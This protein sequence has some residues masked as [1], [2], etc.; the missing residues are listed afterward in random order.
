MTMTIASPRAF[1]LP[2]GGHLAH[3]EG[4][5]GWPLRSI[6]WRPAS[7]AA[8]IVLLNGRG[9]F[10]E[11]YAELVAD[12][13]AK[14]FAVAAMDWRG[15]GLSGASTEPPRRTHIDDFSL[16]VEDAQIWFSAVVA[17]LCPAP[18]K[19]L[20]HS[21]GSHLGLRIL[22]DSP[23]F[24]EKAALLVPMLG[25]QTHPFS[26]KFARR[27]A[28][29]I[30]G[31][32]QGE[33][34]SF[35][36]LPYS[37]LFNNVVR[38]NRLTSDRTRFDYEAAAIA[39]NPNLAIGGVSYGWAVAAFNSCDLLATAG[40]AESIAIPT[41]ILAAEREV[42]VSNDA[43]AAFAARMPHAIYEVIA[44]GRHELLRE[45]DAIRQLVFSKVLDFFESRVA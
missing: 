39:A 29:M 27:V 4:K 16:W 28:K 15:Q 22:H 1:P 18:F 42:L 11:K 40:Y 36:Q 23:D 26:N 5:N 19:L 24:F 14:G 35:G 20:G 3:F 17:K 25:L 31:L 2:E 37:A 6:I 30:V 12:L 21:M 43:S 32:G 45:R 34:F 33:R 44:D 41:L 7:A 9:D 8:T 10:I 13:L 38:M